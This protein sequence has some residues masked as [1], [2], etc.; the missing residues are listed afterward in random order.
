MRMSR[1]DQLTGLT[2]R[3][4][5]TPP[6]VYIV[7][8]HT[9][10]EDTDSISKRSERADQLLGSGLIGVGAV[11]LGKQAIKPSDRMM[12]EFV[13]KNQETIAEVG[14]M[15]EEIK[16]VLVIYTGGTI[17]MKFT[18]ENG[19]LLIHETLCQLMRVQ[20]GLKHGSFMA[21]ERP[22]KEGRSRCRMLSIEAA[23]PLHVVY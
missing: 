11:K 3:T 19:E 16:R 4:C 6:G 8:K 17:G 13:W 18:P 12:N 5:H 20:S 14:S 15:K 7:A 1:R 2:G 9:M 23:L 22:A 21:T 10:S